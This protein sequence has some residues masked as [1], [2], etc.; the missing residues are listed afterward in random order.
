MLNQNYVL[1]L[2]PGSNRVNIHA[3]Q[4][5]VEGRVL[6][7]RFMTG[8]RPFK[9]PEDS[10]CVIRGRKPDSTVFEYPAEHDDFYARVAVEDQM[11]V[12][13]G[14][15][16]CEI[17][18]MKEGEVVGSAN[19]NIVVEPSPITGD[20]ES[21]TEIPAV[22]KMIDGGK[23]GE[24]LTW[25]G[26][27]VDWTDAAKGDMK[28]DVYDTDDDGKVDSAEDADTVSGYT[29][30]RNVLA[31]EYT[32][33]Q[34]DEAFQNVGSELN[35][36]VD[37]EEGKG[38][39]TNDYTDAEQSKLEGIEANAQVNTVTGVK[40]DSEGAYRT[41]NINITPSNIGLGNVDNTADLDKPVSTATQ[42]ELNKKVN[43]ESGKGLSTEDY[44]SEE[45]TKLGNIAAGAQVNVIETVKVDGTAL[46]PADKAVNVDLSGKVDKVQGKG[47]STNDY[48]D[49]EKTKL[50]ALPD[51]STLNTALS[52]K[53]DTLQ[54][55]TT[56][57]QNSTKPVTSGGLYTD[58][59]RQ[60]DAL[61]VLNEIVSQKAD[62]WDVIKLMIE[63]G[64]GA[65]CYPVGSQFVIP[66]AD[67]GN[68]IFD[69]VH[70]ITPS[71]DALHKAML[72]SGKSYGM[73]LLMHNVIY[74][75]QF[76]REEALYYA[77]EGLPAG[78]YNV[79]V[80][81]QPWYG[82]DVGK[83]FQ[84]TLASD[85]PAHGI[86]VWGDYNASRAG[87]NVSVYSD[88]Y[89]TTVLQTAVM[90]EGSDGT[91]LTDLNVFD[92]TMIGSND[93]E[94]SGVRQW[95]N[96][97]VQSNWWEPKTDWDR[98]IG[99]PTRKGFLYG[100]PQAFK[101]AILLSN[102]AN[103]SNTVFDSHGTNQAYSTSDKI[104]LLCNEEC[105]LAQEQSIVCG[106]VFDYY[107]NATN[108]DRIKYDISST[109]T[110][111]GWWLRTPLPHG[112][113]RERHVYTSGA[114][115]DGNAS[116]GLGVAAACVIG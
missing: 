89:S 13:V 37:K 111:R 75:T 82:D 33:I 65:D 49:A 102:H 73:V 88:L 17:V 86:L 92:R 80:T 101:D 87:K 98:I 53:Q 8:T 57:T 31:N 91:A 36:K 41:G 68:M 50:T 29:V 26:H 16:N 15:V 116:G 1:N 112:A 93:W 90:S 3:S 104:F 61:A 39:S 12:L 60:D 58:Q 35:G 7:F 71:S 2:V 25:T 20:E 9:F 48:T 10:F 103:R 27:G 28:K 5:D 45:K 51:N 46:T 97:D 77:E 4:Y 32:N 56:P 84:F 43:A 34:I 106:K 21:I 69:V 55:D 19:F 30:E 79:T 38:L 54:W 94:E 14:T 64:N 76:D 52:S 62:D 113:G 47:L 108:T 107:A 23:V 105:G 115:H 63:S 99:Y 81:R 114:L 78:T 110:A 70:H 74:S 40:G 67:Y 44:T 59:K 42:T 24:V 96:A 95:L 6:K 85:V 72:P 18:I 109:S 100:F 83:T 22:M 11:T 66:H